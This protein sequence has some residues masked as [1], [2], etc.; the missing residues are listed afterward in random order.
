MSLPPQTPLGNVRSSSSS[1]NSI[2]GGGHRQMQ[3]PLKTPLKTPLRTPGGGGGEQLSHTPVINFAAIEAHKENVQ[4]LVQGRSA[5]ALNTALSQ[6]QVEL[7]SQRK[8]FEDLVESEENAES[9]DPLDAWQKYVKWCIDNYPSGQSSESDLLVILER[10]TRLFKSSTQY[11]NDV[12]YLRMWILYARNVDCPSDVYNYLLSNEIGTS[13]ASLYEELALVYEGQECFEKSDETYRMGIHRSAQPIDRLKRRYTEYQSRILSKEG[14]GENERMAY[15]DALRSAMTKAQRSMLGTKSGSTSMSSNS[16]RGMGGDAS[17]PTKSLAISSGNNARK[18]S[19]FKDVDGEDVFAK[20]SKGGAEG[21]A[22]W[23]DLGTTTNRKQE[24]AGTDAKAWKGEILPQRERGATPKRPAIAIYRD[25]DDDEDEEGRTPGKVKGGDVFSKNREPS[26]SDRLRKNPFANYEVGELKPQV[27]PTAQAQSSRDEKVKSTQ[28]SEEKVKKKVVS[29]K[30]SSSKTSSNPKQE[31][32]AIPLAELYPGLDIDQA[33]KRTS[34][35]HKSGEICIEELKAKR[36]KLHHID[37]PWVFLDAQQGQWLPEIKPPQRK[38]PMKRDP[39]VTAFTR[40]AQDEV[41]QMFNNGMVESDDDD[42]SSEDEQSESEEEEEGGQI[43]QSSAL[44][45]NMIQMKEN[46]VDPFTPTPA[47]KSFAIAPQKRSLLGET[48]M[49]N[50][51]LQSGLP[52][53]QAKSILATP[54]RK[55][56][57]GDRKPLAAISQIE[58]QQVPPQK[59]QRITNEV[60]IGED[61][62]DSVQEDEDEKKREEVNVG[63]EEEVDYLN[64]PMRELAPLSPITEATEYTRYTQ[65]TRTSRTSTSN[66]RRSEARTPF[67]SREQGSDENY[68]NADESHYG[69]HL[70]GQGEAESSLHI[71]H[72]EEELFKDQ[73]EEHFEKHSVIPI[74]DT[75][76][77]CPFEK[78]IIDSII[79]NLPLSLESSNDFVNLPNDTA[80]QLTN[81]QKRAAQLTKRRSSSHTSPLIN[82][83]DGTAEWTMKVAQNTFIVRQKLGEGGYGAVFLAEDQAGVTGRQRMVGGIN[84]DASF[85]VLDNDYN[86][87]DD[88]GYDENEP[89]LIAIKVESPPN[90]WEFYILGQLRA[91]LLDEKRLSSIICARKFFCFQDESFLMLEYAEK[92]TLLEIVNSA[93]KA[94]VASSSAMAAGGAIGGSSGSSASVGIDEVLVMFFIIEVIKCVEALHAVDLLHGDL[95]IDNC[96]LRLNESQDSW[97]HSYKRT[98]ENGWSSKGITLI[99]FGRAIDLRQFS[100][101]QQFLANWTPEKH[102][103]PQIHKGEPWRHEIDYFGI[104]SIAYCLLFGKYIEIVDQ[105]DDQYGIDKPLRRYWQTEIWTSLFHLCLNS[106]LQDDPAAQLA[107]IRDKMETW[108]EDNCFRAGKNLK[109]SLKKL[110]IWSMKRSM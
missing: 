85:A 29:S 107:N 59:P 82:T 30:P 33:V 52:N 66:G 37:D 101:D 23:A 4:P 84:G 17:L 10:C 7:R 65:S 89:K 70:R 86:E 1:N 99:D 12:R 27:K 94:G 15:K 62:E 5:H 35:K 16:V 68:E 72:H 19:V 42:E 88:D 79:E 32:Y 73:V 67:A 63:E 80:N 93:V 48:P 45:P 47:P 57:G 95:K 46:E 3:T 49:L 75:G 108:L 25:S 103:M 71:P 58:Q 38:Q 18:P 60:F 104:A 98:G 92:G 43:A 2:F 91:R 54:A 64:R 96:L 13:L 36:M 22:G 87:E 53:G 97:T 8:Q 31:R 28:K 39:T 51:D 100:H 21:T 11:R 78:E 106:T 90:R 69:T 14:R 74:G 55:V 44:K 9:D 20:R 50:T 24:K 61:D 26:E 34:R 40:A 110:E 83:K 109:G 41:L 77:L 105:G 81:L 76:P 102:D 6:R 56:F